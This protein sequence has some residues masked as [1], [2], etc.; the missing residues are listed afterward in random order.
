[1]E[2]QGTFHNYENCKMH[3]R[4]LMPAL[5]SEGGTTLLYYIMAETLTS[6]ANKL[7]E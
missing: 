3:W 7:S 4:R 5:C 1:M 2:A 6:D